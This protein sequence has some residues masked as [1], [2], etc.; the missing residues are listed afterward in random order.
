VVKA[1]YV[2]QLRTSCYHVKQKLGWCPDRGVLL[3][4]PSTTISLSMGL[5]GGLGL[6]GGYEILRAFIKYHRDHFGIP[7][8]PA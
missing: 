8:D 4:S 7:R 1:A 5:Q 2:R 3:S 6:W